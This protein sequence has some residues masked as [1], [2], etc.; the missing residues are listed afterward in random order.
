M[1]E[2]YIP[3]AETLFGVSYPNHHLVAMADN[4]TEAARAVAE[5]RAAG[6]DASAYPGDEVI[7]RHDAYLE[8]R[9]IAQK[10]SALIPSEEE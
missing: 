2:G 3:A 6:F 7:R 5:L 1:A 9:N 10:L 4:A 8:Q